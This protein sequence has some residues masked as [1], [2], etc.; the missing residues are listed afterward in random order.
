M[1]RAH[2]KFIDAVERSGGPEKTAALLDVTTAYI[3][4]LCVGS[5]PS[6]KLA[7]RIHNV[8]HI[9]VQWWTEDVKKKET[10]HESP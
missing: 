6:M 8:L 5:T 9:P 2:A 7:K 3:R 1:T 10:A 4:I